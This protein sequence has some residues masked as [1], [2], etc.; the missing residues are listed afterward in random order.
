MNFRVV[1]A[2]ALYPQPDLSVMML[3]V[4]YRTLTEIW[5]NSSARSYEIESEWPYWLKKCNDRI[6]YIPKPDVPCYPMY[7]LFCT[8]YCQL[9]QL[10]QMTVQF[11]PKRFNWISWCGVTASQPALLYIM[12]YGFLGYIYDLARVRKLS[13]WCMLLLQLNTTG[14]TC[15]ISSSLSSWKHPLFFLIMSPL[16]FQNLSVMFISSEVLYNKRK[17]KANIT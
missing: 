12:Q 4:G 16:R 8:L 17:N 15:V 1:S 2:T 11:K 5:C 7:W 10:D 9:G 13:C 6:D 14:Q 3:N